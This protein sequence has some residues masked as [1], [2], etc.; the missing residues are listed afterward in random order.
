[1]K[2]LLTFVVALGLTAA[3]FQCASDPDPDRRIEDT[4]AEA[5]WH[6]SERFRTEGNEPARRTT[7]Q[8]IVEQYPTSREAERA[9]LVLGGNDVAP[10]APP[11][12]TSG[13]DDDGDEAS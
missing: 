6:L 11:D 12:E 7:L 10:D 2:L 13:S 1:V 9:R 8:Q 3:P 5:L 4:P